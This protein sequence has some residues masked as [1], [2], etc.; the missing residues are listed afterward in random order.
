MNL[1]KRMQ[2]FSLGGLV[3]GSALLA[4][5]PAA[6]AVDVTDV[7]AEIGLATT[8]VAAVGGAVVLLI[9]GFKVYKWVARAF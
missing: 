5:Q 4:S 7:I 3:G 1:S 6:A 8:A 2:L 9:I